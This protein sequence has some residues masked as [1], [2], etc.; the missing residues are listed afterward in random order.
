MILACQVCFQ[1]A[2]PLMRDSLNAGIVVLLGVT[3]VV[4]A[5]FGVFFMTLARRSRAAA[6]LAG[7]SD[8]FFDP[9]IHG[10]GHAAVSGK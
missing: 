8:M 2:D 4:L 7:E 1:G 6:R 10:A 5:C 3:A 9:A